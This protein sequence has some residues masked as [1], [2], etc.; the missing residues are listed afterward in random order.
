MIAAGIVG[1]A[2]A[3]QLLL[4]Y[5]GPSRPRP[6]ARRSRSPLRE[7]ARVGNADVFRLLPRLRRRSPR[8]LPTALPPHQ[9]LR[10]RQALDVGGAGPLARTPPTDRGLRPTLTGSHLRAAAPGRRDRRDAGSRSRRGRAKP[11]AAARNRQPFIEKTGCVSCHHNSVVAVGPADWRRRHGYRFDEAAFEARADAHRHVPGIA[12]RTHACR[13][14]PSPDAQDTISYLLVGL[15]AARATRRQGHGCP[16]A[17]ADAETGGRRAMARGDAP[18]ADRIERHRSDGDVDACSAAVRAEGL[19]GMNATR[20]VER[21][22]DWLASATGARSPR[23]GRSACSGLAWAGAGAEALVSV[24]RA[25]CSR[26]QRSDGGWSQEPAME[27]DAYAT[28]EA[29]V[30]T[31]R[32]W[33]RP[34]RAIQ[35]FV[36]A[37]N[38]CCARSSRMDRGSSSRER[39]RSRCTSKAAFRTAPINGFRRQPRRGP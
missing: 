21:A 20:A 2:P 7:A 29:L 12:S 3:V 8:R 39:C 35:R 11:A 17:V 28:G 4:E 5:E 14:S 6:K 23:T 30:G 19:S 37:W 22:R 10:V 38:T 13:T 25:S 1:A 16:G 34:R 15:S 33:R 24:P 26:V 31:S 18:P 27:S 9:L 32:K 36:V